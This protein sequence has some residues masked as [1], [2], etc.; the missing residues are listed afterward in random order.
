M[1]IRAGLQ[2]LIVLAVLFGASG[3]RAQEPSS[4]V[5][6]TFAP[7]PAPLPAMLEP[8]FLQ[9]T[10]TA[11]DLPPV[12]ERIPQR[13]A[14]VG[15]DGE[16]TRVGRYGGMLDVLGGSAKDTRTL[17]VW[18]YARLVG[19]DPSYTLVPDLAE[20]V[21]IEEGRR[22]TFR[23]RPGHRWS[24]GAPFTAEDFRYWWEDVANDP[25]MSKFGP[26]VELLVDGEK[27]VVEFPDAVTVRYSWSKPNPYFLPALAG[28]Q[29]L[30]LYR[31]SHYLKQF[32]ARHAGLETVQKMAEE[33]DERNWIALHFSKD[34]SYRNDNLDMPTLQPW[35]LKTDPPSDRFLFARNPYYHRVDTAGLQ[36]PYMDQ[37]ALTIA[38]PSLI[39]A[40]AA[41]GETDLQGAYLGFSN[42]TFLK[43]AEE[44]GGYEVRRWLAS[45]GSRIALFP[46]L[47]SSDPVW[48]ELFRNA[49]FRRALS[50]SINREDINN[51][52]FYG[53]AK[54]GN[55]TVLPQS[56]LYKR[57]YLTKWTQYDPDLANMMLES[58]GLTERSRAG[59]RLL[60]DGRPMQIVVETAGEE[61]EQT[62]VLE[63]VRDDWRKIGIGLFIK[64]T[65]REVFYN[66]VKAGSTQ[67]GVW[68]GLEH[69]L[70]KASFSPAELAPLN[71][72]QFQWP[73]WGMWAQTSGQS[74]E[75]PDLESVQRLMALKAEWGAMED[76]ARRTAIWH[77]MLGIWADE[78]FTIGLVQGVDQLVVVS[79]KLRNVPERGIYNFD[80]GAFFGMYRPDTFWFDE[81]EQKTASAGTP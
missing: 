43:R 33:E 58:I 68:S 12:Q 5:P 4:A 76:E 3:G 73:A 11:G 69:A 57:E 26:P 80:P 38:S 30:E 64:P 19:Y 9:A 27:P 17:V 56:P 46:N 14:I 20:S 55:N 39:P 10:V 61:V 72:E 7:A 2:S 79:D 66:R 42:Y 47:N 45:K 78:V 6:P 81:G 75:E 29:P 50:V 44:R 34:R 48:R 74:G 71:P 8:P 13:P 70:P 32:H 60:P 67:I 22:F 41:A 23:L 59:L 54:P 65:Q 24:D 31:P 21:D 53:L 1:N 37:V 77:E 28:A 16:T 35:V 25:E 52:I 40:K 63:L 36:L 51:A 49:D 62:D 15:F 18:G